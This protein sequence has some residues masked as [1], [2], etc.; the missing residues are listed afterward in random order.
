M[1]SLN[2]ECWWRKSIIAGQN[3][4]IAHPPLFGPDTTSLDRMDP[5][6]DL[7]TA[8]WI[9]V[10]YAVSTVDVSTIRC[11]FN[12]LISVVD[13]NFFFLIRIRRWRYFESGSESSMVFRRISDCTLFARQAEDHLNLV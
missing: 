10:P 5:V 2:T 9:Q 4:Y 8:G 7:T 6:P 13:T 3:K 12:E 1:N 11:E